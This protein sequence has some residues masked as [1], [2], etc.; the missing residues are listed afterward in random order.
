MVC[1]FRNVGGCEKALIKIL[2]CYQHTHIT[3]SLF[4]LG[5][6]STNATDFGSRCLQKRLLLFEEQAIQFNSG[7]EVR[8]FR[9]QN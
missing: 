3:I 9:K 6:K 2:Q 5:Q 4:Y 8:C 1:R 7:S